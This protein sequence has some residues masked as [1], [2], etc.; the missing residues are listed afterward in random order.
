MEIITSFI[1]ALFCFLVP[2]YALV[3]VIR[4]HSLDSER[5]TDLIFAGVGSRLIFLF[6]SL[7]CALIIPPTEGKEFTNFA[8]FLALLGVLLLA[9]IYVHVIIKSLVRQ[10]EVIS[11][12]FLDALPSRQLGVDLEYRQQAISLKSLRAKKNSLLKHSLQLGS[13]EGVLKW[14]FADIWLVVMGSLLI[15]VAKVGA[16]SQEVFSLVALQTMFSVFSS[17]SLTVIFACI[18]SA[19]PL[20]SFFSKRILEE[21]DKQKID[22]KQDLLTVF[23]VSIVFALCF[24][25]EADTIDMLS[26]GLISASLLIGMQY[27]FKKTLKDQKMEFL[28]VREK[29]EFVETD[30]RLE[31]VLTIVLKLPRSSY[32]MVA[33]DLLTYLRESGVN[34][35]PNL[36]CG[37]NVKFVEILN[38][39]IHNHRLIG[40]NDIEAAKLEIPIM[41]PRVFR[42]L[43]VPENRKISDGDNSIELLHKTNLA[44][45][46]S[47]VG[48]DS[49]ATE[50]SIAK[51]QKYLG[52][53]HQAEFTENSHWGKLNVDSC[54]KLAKI[55]HRLSMLGYLYIPISILSNM[56]EMVATDV[57]EE[58]VIKFSVTELFRDR[59]RS[60]SGKDGELRIF[61]LEQD[62]DEI[63]FEKRSERVLYIARELEERSLSPLI[64]RV[65]D[66]SN[67]YS[68]RYAE[69]LSRSCFNVKFIDKNIDIR[70]NYYPLGVI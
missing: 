35:L 14:L 60:F 18:I 53:L 5:I 27:Y 19:L 57:E 50:S 67:S 29:D 40:A 43:N 2:A 13:M 58:D 52:Y 15:S 28:F 55:L 34:E 9:F 66:V 39:E 68:K 61:G 11:R 20:I 30:D 21:R 59:P 26:L 46:F 8:S 33:K 7:I 1:L 24:V 62:S 6:L 63:S 64:I 12:F 32:A 31:E 69:I 54:A 16:H 45:L 56:V 49:V 44:R 37:I 36:I 47:E 23:A 22:F 38:P 41:E 42:M 70:S 4:G 10:S 3:I 48:F 25:R 17:V 51:L 65:E